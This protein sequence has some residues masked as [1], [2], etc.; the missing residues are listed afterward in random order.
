M[1]K[2]NTVIA[3]KLTKMAPV[4]ADFEMNIK[5]IKTARYYEIESRLRESLYY[6]L[7]GNK[8]AK[9][10]NFIQLIYCIIEYLITFLFGW[11]SGWG[12]KVGKAS[13]IGIIALFSFTIIYYNILMIDASFKN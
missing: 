10:K 1:F 5:S 9:I 11:L 3:R 7:K 6:I 13:I 12:Q 8:L 2:Q 4:K